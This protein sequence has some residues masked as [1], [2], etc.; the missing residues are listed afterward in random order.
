MIWFVG[1]DDG[2]VVVYPDIFVYVFVYEEVD[3][4][5]GSFVVCC[6]IVVDIDGI[7]ESERY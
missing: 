2:F 4:D 3:V 7:L 6:M 5:D 1:F